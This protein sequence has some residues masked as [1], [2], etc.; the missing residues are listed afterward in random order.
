VKFI[1]KILLVL[2]IAV[3]VIITGLLIFNYY[4][5]DTVKKEIV[6]QLNQYLEVEVSVDEIEMDVLKQFPFISV[7][8]KNVAAQ[9]KYPDENEK[10]INAGEISVLFNIMEVIRGNY[11]LKKIILKNAFLNI[12]VHPDGKANY[13]VVK[14]VE[15]NSTSGFEIDVTDVVFQ[16]VSISYVH[17]PSN[18]EYLFRI[19]KG[20]LTGEFSQSNQLIAFNGDLFTTHIKSGS[21]N[22][23]NN[24]EV[25]LDLTMEIDRQKKA[26]NIENGR[27]K[28]NGLKFSIL[29]KIEKYHSKPQLDLSI[30]SEKADLTVLL[31]TIPKAFLEPIS[32]F[33]FNGLIA[34]NAHIQGAFAANQVPRIQINFEVEDGRFHYVAKK[35]D[36]NDIN[37]S[38]SFD[39]G[40]YH[41]KT[42]YKLIIDDAKIHL[43]GGLLSGQIAILNFT[44]PNVS[45]DFYTSF[46][47]VHL[48]DYF[49]IE[50]LN[51]IS[52][53]LEIDM[54]FKNQ[55]QDFRRFTVNDFI[56]S[57]TQGVMKVKDMRF[58]LENSTH[59]FSNF[60]GAFRFNN[61]DLEI[62]QFSGDVSNTDFQLT[63]TFRNILAFALTDTEPVFIDADLKS[64]KIDLGK[65]IPK[66]E[67]KDNSK[68]LR[69]SDR[70]NYNFNLQ[71]SEFNFRK[72][73]A[74]GISGNIKQHNRIV[75]ISDASF[76]S[77]EGSVKLSGK[78]NGQNPV[79]HIVSCNANF[80][81]VNIEKLFYEFGN[82]GQHNLTDNHIR[83]TVNAEIEYNSTLSP[84]LKVS[85]GTVY[86][87][88]DISISDGELI[89]YT[90]LLKLSK[91]IKEEELRHVKF[92]NLNNKVRIQNE[93]I[94]IPQMDIKSSRVSSIT[95]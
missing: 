41:N 83:G 19:N 81:N 20:N 92:S 68:G 12:I 51:D 27:I 67:S 9:G 43:R 4:R 72:F 62:D 15:K 95:G 50:A 42:S 6:T 2:I 48:S 93:V 28:T 40:K 1:R 84:Y 18:Q 79:N 36:L 49:N 30:S 89:N 90:P 46:N 58:E 94:H 10:L 63:G 44:K 33:K 75:T 55:L 88:A 26:I 21:K 61:K 35:I 70:I 53:N 85:P 8:F 73:K 80:K 60:N 74:S 64:K 29:G 91:Y 66:S 7:G 31:K 57:S 86:T 76:Q 69:F 34:T 78:I 39:N 24:S 71:V 65:L 3:T 47:L 37:F 56:T 11:V 87:L 54:K 59:R 45:V 32:D 23:L 82:F 5:S 16:N 25:L 17:Y 52:G 22:Y 14:T 13:Q 77:M 38:G